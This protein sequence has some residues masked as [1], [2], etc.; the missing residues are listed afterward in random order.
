M[1]DNNENYID[2]DLDTLEN[3]N[4]EI[5]RCIYFLYQDDKL[6]Y[7]GKTNNL[8]QR[9]LQHRYEKS[10]VF[11]SYKKYL[12]LEDSNID[13]IENDFIKKYNPEYN[14]TRGKRWE[15]TDKIKYK[16]N[17]VMPKILNLV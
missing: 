11:N 17:F 15:P 4:L 1:I 12:I 14:I 10:K 8:V 7:I 9:L 3:L 16:D 5:V 13:E 2:L 6:V